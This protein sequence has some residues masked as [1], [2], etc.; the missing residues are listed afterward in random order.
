MTLK[1]VSIHGQGNATQEYV[2]LQA[3]TDLSLEYYLL[4]DTTYSSATTVSNKVRHTYWFPLKAVKAGELVVVC[5]GLGTDDSYLNSA[6]T[7][8]HRFFWNLKTPVWNNTGDAA[9]LF[10]LNTWATTKA[11]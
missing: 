3:S 10:S 7:K 1:V 5:T 6:G 11:K 4:A 9:I 2:L 8:V